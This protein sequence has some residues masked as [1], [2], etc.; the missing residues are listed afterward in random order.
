MDEVFDVTAENSFR[1]TGSFQ[2]IKRPFRKTITS[3]VAFSCINPPFWHKT[4]VT[5]KHTNNLHPF[6]HI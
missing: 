3:P 6:K 2:K 5:H 1:V 4:P